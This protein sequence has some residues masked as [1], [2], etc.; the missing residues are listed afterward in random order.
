MAK[1]SLKSMED[2]DN[3]HGRLHDLLR[4]TDTK[5]DLDDP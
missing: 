3:L 1:T 5:D 2:F 4:L